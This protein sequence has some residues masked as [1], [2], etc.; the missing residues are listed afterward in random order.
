MK[1]IRLQVVFLLNKTNDDWWHVRKATG[2]DGFVP[3][4]YVK[5]IE[6]KRVPVQVRQPFTVQDF[7]RV[8]RTR[9][10]KKSF[11]VRKPKPPPKAAGLMDERIRAACNVSC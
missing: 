1:R 4:N 5:E 9:M 6:G 7:R 2:K 3:A 11:P 10:V 8:K